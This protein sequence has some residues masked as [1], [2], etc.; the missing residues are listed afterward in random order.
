MG[1]PGSDGTDDDDEAGLAARAV[2][3]R[4]PMTQTTQQ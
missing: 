4:A 1:I 3:G 2:A